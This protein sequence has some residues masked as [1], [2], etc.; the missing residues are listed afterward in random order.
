MENVVPGCTERTLKSWVFFVFSYQFLSQ[1]LNC[2]LRMLVL[3]T[4]YGPKINEH[5]WKVGTRQTVIRQQPLFIYLWVVRHRKDSLSFCQSFQ[6][7]IHLLLR[8]S[9]TKYFTNHSMTT[10]SCPTPGLEIIQHASQRPREVCKQ[11]GI[12][13]EYCP[14]EPIQSS[15]HRDRVGNRGDRTCQKW[16]FSLRNI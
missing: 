6:C 10:V 7:F 16:Q 9:I 5:Q 3:V 12:K 13:Q 1:I 8:Q 15:S 2:L 11:P 4:W 14:E